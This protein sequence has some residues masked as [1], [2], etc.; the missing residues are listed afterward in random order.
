M[1]AGLWWYHIALAFVDYVLTLAFSH[2][3]V[4][5]GLVVSDG[6]WPLGLQAEL[7]D[8]HASKPMGW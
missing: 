5:L 4:L 8:P 3:I 2:L 7:V 6:N 1:I